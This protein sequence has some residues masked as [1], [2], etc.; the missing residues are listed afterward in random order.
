MFIVSIILTVLAAISAVIWFA[1]RRA[2]RKPHSDE[3]VAA[4]ATVFG[5]IAVVLVG[6]TVVCLFFAS[7]TTVSANTI[8]VETAFGKP[9]GVAQPGLHFFA[10]WVNVEGFSTRVQVTGRKAGPEGDTPQADCVQVNLKGGA[11]A[12]ADMT[13]RY[14][15]NPSDVPDLWRKYGSF[16]IARD[17][18]LRSATDNAAKIVYGQYAPQD[19][20]SGAALPD[21][22]TKMTTA[23]KDQL[24]ASGL[25]LITVAPGQLHLA[26]DVQQRI[27]DILNAQTATTVAQ[28]NLAKNQAEAAANQAL[29]GSL[30]E[31]ILISQ[32]MQ[33]AERIKP[34]VFNCFP[35][36]SSATPLVNVNGGR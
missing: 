10:P 35:G 33:A 1:A 25:T 8:G 7:L 4:A 17:K 26:P 2:A 16:D 21:I 18:L 32:C 19:A 27:N 9:V 6:L 14:V 15:V 5:A 3:D 28:Q 23:L 12:C 24:G 34:A 31:Q 36:G 29:T 30:S 22:T 11:G 20:I 13:I